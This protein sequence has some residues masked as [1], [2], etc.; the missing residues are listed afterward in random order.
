[1]GSFSSTRESPLS[2]SPTR[3][4]TMMRIVSGRSLQ[5]VGEKSTKTLEGSQGVE[6]QVTPNRVSNLEKEDTR[7][8]YDP[9]TFNSGDIL[10]EDKSCVGAWVE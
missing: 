1:M 7:R 5:K 9:K 4:A 2:W 6:P 10:L 8:V 3:L